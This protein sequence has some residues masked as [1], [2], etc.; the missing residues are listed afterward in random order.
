METL[1]YASPNR[2]VTWDALTMETLVYA[3]SPNGIA[4][5]D[6]FTEGLTLTH[7]MV[8]KNSVVGDA[9]VSNNSLRLAHEGG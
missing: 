8:A 5:T 2:I 3:D 4:H 9:P 6:A 1:V 7:G